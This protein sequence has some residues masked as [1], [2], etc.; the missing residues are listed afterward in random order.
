MV[1]HEIESIYIGNN[2]CDIS[3]TIISFNYKIDGSFF[4]NTWKYCII[5]DDGTVDFHLCEKEFKNFAEQNLSIEEINI[6]NNTKLLCLQ[7]GKLTGE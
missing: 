4:N 3:F 6:I 7:V 1:I 5:V 2:D